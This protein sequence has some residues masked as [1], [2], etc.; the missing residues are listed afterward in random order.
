M[1]PD[2]GAQCDVTNVSL[3]NPITERA[4]R[5]K[6]DRSVVKLNV[7]LEDG[8]LRSGTAFLIDIERGLFLTALH[9]VDGNNLKIRGY[10]PES[11]DV[12]D[13]FEFILVAGVNH[14]YSERDQHENSVA[15]ID[16]AILEIT[17]KSLMELAFRRSN[18]FDLNFKLEDS[19]KPVITLG[20]PGSNITLTGEDY[21]SWPGNIGARTRE[22][23]ASSYQVYYKLNRA[24]QAGESGGPMLNQVGKVIGI[25]SSTSNLAR[26]Y[27]FFTTSA[28]LFQMITELPVSRKAQEI[29]K[30]L[31][32][33]SVSSG[34]LLSELKDRGSNS[35]RNIDIF[36]W[37]TKVA[38]SNEYSDIDISKRC[39]LLALMERRDMWSERRMYVYMDKF[40]DK[41]LLAGHLNRSREKALIEGDI[42]SAQIYSELSKNLS[43]IT[44]KCRWFTDCRSHLNAGKLMSVFAQREL[45]IMIE[46]TVDVAMEAATAEAE[47][48][49]EA[50]EAAAEAM[51]D[52]AM[53]AAAE[54]MDAEDAEVILLEELEENQF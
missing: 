54:A 46:D 1:S 42:H 52:E 44:D 27:S 21:E 17:D 4:A 15:P 35:F 24:T 30:L 39:I 18:E 28:D 48:M 8:R 36:E 50:M 19:G 29:E 38:P 3:D 43:A 22:K 49:D 37:A 16:A 47:V 7:Y 10:R 11:K 14:G 12:I 40:L 5:T 45:E 23:F 53:E 9:V 41:P 26:G 34:Q 31:R 51:V 6:Y 2:I 20:Y 32:D 33:K 13:R 25:G